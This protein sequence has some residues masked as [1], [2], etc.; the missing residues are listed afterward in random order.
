MSLSASNRVLSL[1]HSCIGFVT[2]KTNP[3]F[4]NY[5]TKAIALH[6]NN[7]HAQFLHA[8]SKGGAQSTTAEKC[9]LNAISQLEFE[10]SPVR[11]IAY[12]AFGDYCAFVLKDYRKAKAAFRKASSFRLSIL[13]LV[14]YSQSLVGEKNVA[15]EVYKQLVWCL[16]VANSMRPSFD[17]SPVYVSITYVYLELDMR[18][19]AQSVLDLLLAKGLQTDY[20]FRCLAQ[21]NLR[22]N[23]LVR[24][25]E[26]LAIA[27]GF[28]LAYSNPFLLR[29]SAAWHAFNGMY[30]EAHKYIN[31]AISLDAIEPYSWEMNGILSYLIHSDV[32]KFLDCLDAALK[33]RF[34]LSNLRMKGQALFELQRYGESRAVFETI[35]ENDPSDHMSRISLVVCLEAIHNQVDLG[36]IHKNSCI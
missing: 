35:L 21:I 14:A 36:C 2:R 31:L 22:R 11:W 25:D 24:T 4:D 9:F 8:C 23:E 1:A 12:L 30:A 28:P 20:S 15:E 34:D 19:E 6:D 27:R 10:S 18:D 13:P 33:L 7:A 32:S 29:S 5:Y 3:N 16:C 17:V 26:N